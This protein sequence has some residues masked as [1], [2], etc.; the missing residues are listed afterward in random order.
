MG[1]WES[2]SGAQERVSD[3]DCVSG[4]AVRYTSVDW[5]TRR[6]GLSQAEVRSKLDVAVT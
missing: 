4:V 5:G 3:G 6:P 2:R 1:F